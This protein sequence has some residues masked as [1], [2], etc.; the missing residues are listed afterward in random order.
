MATVNGGFFVKRQTGS[1]TIS[2]TTTLVT[3]PADCLFMVFQLITK[4]NNS[5]TITIAGA[6][7]TPVIVTVAD[8]NDTNDFYRKVTSE[9]AHSPF[10]SSDSSNPEWKAYIIYPGET[11]TAGGI[12]ASTW[13]SFEYR[14]FFGN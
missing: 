5:G 2:G 3:C 7:V 10:N 6:T 13:H 12:G 4:T 8:T 11:V 1:A 14:S 9:W